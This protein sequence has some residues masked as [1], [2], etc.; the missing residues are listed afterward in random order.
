MARSSKTQQ[1]SVSRRRRSQTGATF[2]A[3][4]DFGATSGRVIVGRWANEKLELTEVHRFANQFRSLGLNEYWDVPYL[5]GEARTGLL[6]AKQQF[7]ALASVGVDTWGVDHVLVNAEGRPVY[8]VHA[9]RD[10]RTEKLSQRFERDGFAQIYALTGIPNYP[11][12]SSLQ[13]QETLAAC[14]ETA[15]AAARCLFLPDFFNFLLSGKMENEISICSHSQLLDARGTDWSP[16]AL[17][18]FGI[19]RHWFSKPALAARILGPVRNFPELAGVK[20][21]LVP[22]HDTAC[23]FAAMPAAPDGSDLYLSSGTWSL[24]G[25]ESDSPVLGDA[26]RAARVSNERSG[27]GRYRPLRS[28]LGLWLLEQTLPAFASRPTSPAAWKRLIAAARAA[29]APRQ[30][31]D[32]NDSTL[33]NPPAMRAAIDAQLRSQ[34]ARPPRDLAGYVRLIC[35]SLARGHADAVQTFEKLSGRKFRRI[36]IVGGG[37]KNALLCQSTADASGLPV[38]SYNLEGS[39]VGNIANQLIALGA[40]ESLADFRAKLARQLEATTYEPARA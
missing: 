28:C 25:F 30:L 36:L 14:P 19:P 20:S 35:D 29:P 16:E 39:A 15:D 22:G 34:R 12:N 33:F 9:Y 21:V 7:P 31:L 2:C 23:A 40:V 10:K 4:V 3:A 32:V 13:L 38:A 27:D 24:L 5:W 26:A 1:D 17:A 8:P 6:K 11:Y 37:S 18:Y